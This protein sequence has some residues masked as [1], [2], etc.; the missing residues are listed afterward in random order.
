M[1]ASEWRYD[2]EGGKHALFSHLPATSSD[3]EEKK[4]PVGHL[5]RLDK[6][7]FR[8]TKDPS[9]A[10]KE[11]Q[12]FLRRIIKPRFRQ[13]LDLPEPVRVPRS[14]V[15]ELRSN[16]LQA[17][18]CPIPEA[19]KR[20]WLLALAGDDDNNDCTTLEN[21]EDE[22]KEEKSLSGWMIRDY[23]MRN[24]NVGISIGTNTSTNASSAV[25]TPIHTMSF[26]L[27]PKAGYVAS[28]PLVDPAH[29]SKFHR[30][31]FVLL[32]EL[33]RLGYQDQVHRGWKGDSKDIDTATSSYDP[34]DLFSKDDSARMYKALEA[35][36]DC[37]QNNFKLWASTSEDEDEPELVVADPHYQQASQGESRPE[38]DWGK[39]IGVE[40]PTTRATKKA[41]ILPLLQAILQAE[42]GF[43]DQLRSWQ[44]H[45]DVLD[46]DGAQI[47]YDRL[48]ELCNGS[49]KEAQALLDQGFSMAE[50]KDNNSPPS[51]NGA[52]IPGSPFRAPDCPTLRKLLHLLHKF[53]SALQKLQTQSA[54]SNNSDDDI[55][56]FLQ[57]QHEPCRKECLQVIAQIGFSKE[58]CCYLLQNWLLSLA[59]CDVSFFV[60]LWPIAKENP[61]A[62]DWEGEGKTRIL[63][64]Q[65]EK[66]PGSMQLIW[67][68]KN[69]KK[70]PSTYYHYEIK[71]I[72]CD[73]KPS[74]KLRDRYKKEQIGR[75][76]V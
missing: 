45:L 50:D 41:R 7:L 39:L 56:Q 3:D 72:D 13:Y 36:W 38:P 43:L 71:L 74:K 57:D 33:D 37:P 55:Q 35:L 21:E 32:Q 68:A 22:D 9:S 19:R 61:A 8:A 12:V 62:A 14:F 11:D 25:S 59:L 31:R 4:S 52:T 60:T 65:T 6:Q 66:A 63:Q 73:P 58:A 44:Q 5:L 67:S 23:R 49:H 16:V 30:S 2:G 20:D 10:K 29:R 15:R 42:T 17:E 1:N 18:P 40:N 26:E 24:A 53:S 28:S 27:K 46:G 54:D 75:A 69:E 48:V 34:L 51:K 64:S 70:S 76:H 47:V